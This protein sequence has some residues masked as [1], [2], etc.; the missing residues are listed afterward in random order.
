MLTIFGLFVRNKVIT[1]DDDELFATQ[2][3]TQQTSCQ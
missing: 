2:H 1:T 3:S